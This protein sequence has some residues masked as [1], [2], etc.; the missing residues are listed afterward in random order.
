M[1]M[2]EFAMFCKSV[3][4]AYGYGKEEKKVYGTDIMRAFA[5]RIMFVHGQR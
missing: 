3:D 1:D 5:I 2:H 4:T